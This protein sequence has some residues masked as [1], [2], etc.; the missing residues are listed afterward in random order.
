[1]SA[2]SRIFVFWGINSWISLPA[3]PQKQQKNNKK[4]TTKTKTKHRDLTKQT[5]KHTKAK[6]SNNNVANK[7]YPLPNKTPF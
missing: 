3:S 2:N 6:Q 1:M 4:K 7:L 5:N